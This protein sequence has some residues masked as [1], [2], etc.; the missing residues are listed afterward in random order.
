MPA[1]RHTSTFRIRHYE[2]DGYGH[3]NHVNY[4]RFMQEAALD[5]SAAVGWDTARYAEIGHS[6]LIRETDIEYLNAL[7]YGESVAI[8]TWVEDFRRVRSRRRYDFRRESDNEQIARAVTDWV[9]V[10]AEGR[11]AQVPP[12]MIADY[13]VEQEEAQARPAFP[14]APAPPSQVFTLI[15][16]VAWRDIDTAG[17]M[18]NAATFSYLE[19]AAVEVGRYYGW[20][21]E[22]QVEAGFAWV[23]RRM[24]L[25]YLQPAFLGDEL[26]IATWVSP[27]RRAMINRHYT[28]KRRSDQALIAQAWADWVCFDLVRQRPTRIPEAFAT[29][30]APNIAIPESP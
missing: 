29:D 3:L 8:T 11:P 1:A 16:Q 18:N 5:A 30:M 23:M 7:H 4:V 6:W 22:R 15:R 19:D 21:M 24:R 25:Q 28:V 27:A 10:D 9:Y 12:E 26:E 17:H 20:P 2:C 14:Q 13:G